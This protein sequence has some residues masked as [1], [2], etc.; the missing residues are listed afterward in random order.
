MLLCRPLFGQ[1]INK[2]EYFFDS[3][4]GAG[5][6]TTV[7]ITPGASINAN[8][9]VNVSALATGPHTL[10]TRVKDSN[11]R[12]SHFQSRSFFI[13]P[14]PSAV[15]PAINL[16]KAEYFIDS[17]PGVGN[18][19]A[20]AVTPSPTINQNIAIPTTSL[21][22]GFH[23]INVRVRDDK[24]RWTHFS[25]RS[26]F[27]LTSPVLSTQL[28]KAEYFFDT[29][30]GAGN[31]TPL[32]IAAS[33]SQTNSFALSTSSLGQGFHNIGIRYR[34]NLGRWS[35]F[36]QR[37]F[38]VIPANLLPTKLTQ[39]E[40]YVDADPGIGL[41]SK[42]SFTPSPILDQ[43]FVVDVSGTPVGSHN[44][45]VRTKDDKGYWSIDFAAAFT[46]L[47]CTPPQPPTSPGGSVCGSGAVTLTAAGA[48]GAQLYRWYADPTTSTVLFTGASFVTPAISSTTVYY[49]TIY[50]PNTTCESL[51]TAVTA[52]V[53]SSTP[54]VLNVTG[55]IA[56]CSGNSITLSAPAG[57]SS[58]QWSTGASTQ[59]I[60]VN[61]SGSYTV[62]VGNGTC[63][64][65]A[66]LPAIVTVAPRPGK[67]NVV[68]TATELCIGQTATLQGPSA[69]AAY[70]WSNGGAT[71]QITINQPGT[72]SLVVVDA[73]GC[74][75]FPSDPVLINAPPPKPAILAVGSTT[76]CQGQGVTL[77]GPGGMAS[78]LWSSGA[79]SQQTT[80]VT[81]GSYTVQTT[82]AAG[83]TSPVSDPI[84]VNVNPLPPKPTI[85]TSGSTSMCLG[86]TIDL[87]APAGFSYIWSTGAATQQITINQ[88]G[89]YTVVVVDA[90]SCQSPAADPVVVTAAPCDSS[91]P[92]A[93]QD[94]VVTCEVKGTATVGLTDLFSDPDDDLDLSSLKIVRPLAS[95]AG[96]SIDANLTLTVDYTN[97]LFAGEEPLT[98]EICDLAKNCTRKDIEI[99]VV[100]EVVVYN[101]VSPNGDGLNELLYLEYIDLLDEAK[102]NRVRIFNRWGDVVYDAENY[103]NSTIAF[104]GI[105]TNGTILPTG[106]YFY[107]IDFASGIPYKSGYISLRK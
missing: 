14:A 52:G 53:V 107:R 12:W 15:P 100:G 33:S 17:D 20:I 16:T 44:L 98:L 8:F 99:R 65:S 26:F 46:I 87:S 94:K 34:D 39:I 59:Q 51:R 45:Y 66:S 90:K 19:T 25:A 64:T 83:C 54:P 80:A 71:Q 35:L 11:G 36:G 43:L 30:P 77:V 82:D 96:A 67:P 50:D 72:Y 4:P 32:P 60:T 101:A 2:A 5:N 28:T 97:S 48:T 92:P 73:N 10:N 42:L 3:D 93:I 88:S 106:T 47:G 84:A 22:T 55:N 31:A 63:Q 91:H 21:S 49:A 69:F 9:S 58:Y 78:Y 27:V 29:D 23:T 38:F 37:S 81:A 56:I 1:V 74:S 57:F 13:L 24:G 105:G 75:S 41:A 86:Q 7:T 104:R 61:S 76:F 62:I 18:A 70:V 95:G 68:A 79:L 89:S 6:G 40:Y 102:Q 103:N 85:T